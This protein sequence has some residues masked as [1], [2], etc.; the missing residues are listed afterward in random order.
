MDLGAGQDREDSQR[1]RL[2]E[3]LARISDSLILAT[4][5]PHDGNDR[6]F[7]SLCELLDPSL[8]DG[9]GNL[10]GEAYRAH[11]VRRLKSHIV[12]PETGAE[13][14]KRRRVFPC[15]VIVA[16]ARHA[17]FMALQRRLVELIGPMLRSA[18]RNRRF[19]EALGIYLARSSGASP[20]LML[21]SERWAWCRSA[22]NTR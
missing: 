11:V 16:P 12:D 14:F 18:F 19:D 7:A 17:N 6:S 1:R 4:A 10:R 5:T 22:S 2:A 15:P 3:V 9:R 21:A 13:R 8:I 20:L